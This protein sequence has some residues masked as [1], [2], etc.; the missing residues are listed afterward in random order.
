MAIIGAEAGSIIAV[1]IVVHIKKTASVSPAVQVCA[2][3]GGMAAWSMAT[4]DH[5]A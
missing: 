2:R 5:D 3:K 1:I 4:I